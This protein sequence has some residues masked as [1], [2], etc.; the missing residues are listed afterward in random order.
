MNVPRKKVLV[1]MSGGVDSSMT[2]KLLLEQGYPVEGCYMKLHGNE[3]MHEQNIARVER[4][5]RY[6][7][8]PWHV[9]DRQDLFHQ[10]VYQPFI[11]IY[12]QGQTPNPCTFC[13]R[14]IKFG[15]LFEFARELDCHHLATGHYV[16]CDGQYIY[17]GDDPGKDQSYFLFN[18]EPHIIPHLL[19][20]LGSWRKSDVKAMAADIPL[21]A[22]LATQ[23]ESSEICFVEDSYIDVLREHL[24]VDQPG[25]V[26]DTGG[27]VVGSHKGYM[28]YTVGQRKGFD[29]PLS[30][31]ALYVKQ[32][33]PKT[34]ELV[35]GTREE[36]NLQRFA[37][38]DLNLFLPDP[39]QEFTCE[40][41]VRYRNPKAPARVLL[42]AGGSATIELERPEYAIAPG[43][44]AAFYEGTRLLGG[45]YIV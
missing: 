6:F 11:D 34:N 45:G 22:S 42:G 8:I 38:R 31:T 4:V 24:Q 28:H 21:L 12:S 40:V 10:S 36:I 25:K 32:I 23:K 15:T 17:Q 18:I 30:H 9:L 5:A 29:V 39:G 44:A 19:F 14:L 35:V 7:N 43:Q 1:A 37:V 26:L 2:T 41:K 33:L 13:N 20:P 3:Q 27:N 16:K